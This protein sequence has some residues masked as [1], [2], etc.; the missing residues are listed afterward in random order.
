MQH[1]SE[2]WFH[3]IN[4]IKVNTSV[5]SFIMVNNQIQDIVIATLHSKTL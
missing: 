2:F 1:Q 5:F 4:P 3:P